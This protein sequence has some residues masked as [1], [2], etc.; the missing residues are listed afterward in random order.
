MSAPPPLVLTIGALHAGASA[1]ILADAGVIAELD[2]RCACVATAL[3]PRADDGPIPLPHR[4]LEKQL[5]GA[6][7]EPPRAVRVGFLPSA[8]AAQSVVEAL[9]ARAPERV[10]LAPEVPAGVRSTLFALAALVVVR[11][12]DAR[13]LAS[14]R[15]AASF[16][17]DA[18]ATAVLVTGAAIGGRIVDLLDD[19]GQVTALDT[20]RIQAPRVP[21][22]A[23]AHAAALTAH[24]ARGESLAGAAE[25]SQRYVALRLRRAR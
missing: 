22:L 7:A 1:G 21:G 24:L 20:S 12:E 5:A 15:R 3:V 10:V 8:R 17:R 13:D 6:L 11:S 9:E 18:G 14:L 25:A 16:L 19:G 4:L 2:S 23:A